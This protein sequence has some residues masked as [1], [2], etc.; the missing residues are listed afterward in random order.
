MLGKKILTVSV[1]ILLL[2]FIIIPFLTSNGKTE[3]TNGDFSGLSYTDAKG[4]QYTYYRKEDAD[5]YEV[6][7]SYGVKGR[8][9]KTFDIDTSSVDITKL[10]AVLD[11]STVTITL[12]LD[13]DVLYGGSLIYEVYFVE[14]TH[15]HPDDL[16]DT[17]KFIETM[18][19]KFTGE[20]TIFSIEL[21]HDDSGNW[22]AYSYPDLPSLTGNAVDN[23][24]TFTVSTSDLESVGITTGSGFG[25]YAVCALHGIG[26]F[27]TGYLKTEV[28]WDTAG[29]GAASAPEEFNTELFVGGDDKDDSEV[30]PLFAATCVIIIIVVIVIIIFVGVRYLKKKG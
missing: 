5:T 7:E 23:I 30:D 20:Q 17:E 2:L 24:I 19:M 18:L 21:G 16:V 1:S 29:V 6:V 22:Y 11:S 8:H 27:G 26:G 25:L 10:S 28:T 9:S 4:D 3:L 13:G 12:E 14:S 15:Q